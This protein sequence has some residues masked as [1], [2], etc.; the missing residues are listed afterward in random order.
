MRAIACLLSLIAAALSLYVFGRKSEV[1]HAAPAMAYQKAKADALF[2][3]SFKQFSSTKIALAQFKGSPLIVYFWAS[4]CVECRNEAKA[5]MVLQQQHRSSQLAVIGIGV[6]QSDSL[7]RFTR[8]TELTYPVFVAGRDGIELS[9]RM[10]N[11]LGEMPFVAVIDR[12]GILVAK[13]F[14]KFAPQTLDAMAA[15][16]Q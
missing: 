7:H 13:H 16:L 11:L 9:R 10:G 1:R 5:L 8:D 12:H 4:W 3:S 14:G 6:D 15:A 2:E